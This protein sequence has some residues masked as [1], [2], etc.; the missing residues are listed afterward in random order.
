MSNE[1]FNDDSKFGLIE[2]DEQKLYSE[3]NIECELYVKRI[4]RTNV[5]SIFKMSDKSVQVIFCD[6]AELTFDYFGKTITYTPK[7]GEKRLFYLDDIRENE[8]PEFMKH[9]KYVQKLFQKIS[10]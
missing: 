8:N 4:L 7:S 9:L 2:S 10:I 3:N 6:L 5:A 1:I